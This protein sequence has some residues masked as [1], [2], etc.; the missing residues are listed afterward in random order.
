MSLIGKPDC[1]GVS[2]PRK[3]GRQR[4]R[5]AKQTVS[6]LERSGAATIPG[7]CFHLEPGEAMSDG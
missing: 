7:S 6:L 2:T 5:E 1:S 4:K 3:L